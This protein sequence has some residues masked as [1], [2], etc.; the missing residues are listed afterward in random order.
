M[1]MSHGRIT[2][3]K[4][5]CPDCKS[6]CRRTT[7]APGPADDPFVQELPLGQGGWCGHDN[8]RVTASIAKKVAAFLLARPAVMH[9]DELIN[10]KDPLQVAYLLR[11]LIDEAVPVQ[12]AF[13]QGAV[14]FQTEELFV[15]LLE[16]LTKCPVWSV[17][18]G[19]LHSTAP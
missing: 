5:G 9:L 7:G 17:N 11:H 16:F 19:E 13:L 14:P 1:K 2:M 15:R 3:P 10:K 12:V 18:L 4:G 6:F 8:D